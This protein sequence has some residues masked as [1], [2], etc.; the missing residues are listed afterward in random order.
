VGKIK[1][2]LPNILTFS[3][4]SLGI[5]AILLAVSKD[6]QSILITAS[7]LI[8]IAAL[9]DRFDGQVARKLGVESELGKELDSLSDLISFGVAPVIIA[10]K[11]NFIDMNYWGYLLVLCFPIAGA[12]RLAKYNV[13]EFDNVFRGIPITIAGAFLSINSMYNSTQI[14]NGKFTDLHRYITVGLI[15][16]LSY[17]MVSKLKIKKL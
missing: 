13:T 12:Y 15:V 17:L 16:V 2:S 1:A 5:I 14:M 3:N 8:M 6:S 7:L 4:L 9:T 10:W 11:I